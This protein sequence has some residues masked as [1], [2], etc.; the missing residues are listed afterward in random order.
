[1][2]SFL[3]TG[4]LAA[5]TVAAARP[6]H[7]TI[8][9]SP[10]AARNIVLAL[11]ISRSM[12]TDDFQS[13]SGNIS[14]LEGVKQVV[15]QFIEA[16]AQDRLGLVVFGSNAYLQSPLTLDHNVLQDLVSRLDVG[17]A[18]DG[19]AMG[20]GLGL[21]LKRIQEIEG[22]SKAVI[23]LTDGVSNAGHV[24]PLKAAKV[25]KELGVKVH[26]IG[27]GS[28][29]TISTVQRGFFTQQLMAQAEFDEATLQQIA[30]ITGGVYFNA[31]SIEG[32]EKV[33]AQIDKLERSENTEPERRVVEE[34][35]M[36]YASA[37]LLLY[38]LYVALARTVFLKVP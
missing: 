38:L 28:S 11:D 13:R 22:S 25:A 7:V 10:Y 9:T 17:I 31:N 23:L 29:S 30:D 20:D 8:S 4:F 36:P 35:F 37:A 24:N 21:S 26:T 27:I 12:S 6:Q 32:L 5:I 3:A 34:L 14:R 33:Y 2:L 16:R 15:D 18:G 19:T 1:V